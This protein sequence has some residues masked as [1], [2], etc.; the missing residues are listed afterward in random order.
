MMATNS[1][2]SE[3]WTYKAPEPVG[4]QVYRA[5]SLLQ[6]HRVRDAIQDAHKG[7]IPPLIGF[8]CGLSSPPVAKVAAQLGY[9]VVFVDWEHSSTNVETMTQMVHDIQYISE[10]KSMAFV[11]VPGHDH[12]SIGH[13]LDAGA[14]IIVPQVDTVEQAKHVAAASR[15][16]AKING[17]RSAPPFRWLQGTSDMLIDS[18]LSLW[19][20]LNHQSAVIIQIE[21]AEGI[22]NLDAMLTEVGDQIDSVWLGSLDARVSMGLQNAYGE[23]P[24]WMKLKALYESTL[25]KHNM[26]SSGLALG[27][28]AVRAKMAKGKSF[29]VSGSDVYGIL[30]QAAGLADMRQSFPQMNYEQVYDRI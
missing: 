19:E 29:M 13:A 30:G 14:S 25:R 22:R 11:R 1:T 6:P 5:P 12:A 23:E 8:F 21:S 28:P 4:M 2:K 16:G 3:K 17:K 18:S 24:E 7:T 15:F 27:P 10:G 20:N 9:D 26:P